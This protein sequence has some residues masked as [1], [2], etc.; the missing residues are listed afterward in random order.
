MGREGGRIGGRGGWREG[1]GEAE[2]KRVLMD[3]TLDKEMWPTFVFSSPCS[4]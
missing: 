3:G 4:R 2:F 1:E